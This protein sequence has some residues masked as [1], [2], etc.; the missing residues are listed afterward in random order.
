MSSF[1]PL[2]IEI[3]EELETIYLE[4]ENL[5]ADNIWEWTQKYRK[6]I[7]G[8]D[9]NFDL[10]PF[11]REFYIDNHQRKGALC[12]RQVYKSTAATDLLAYLPTTKSFVS[13]GYI[14]HDPDSLEAFSTER[15]REGTFMA[16][17]ELAKF[18]P[19]GRA[20]VKTIKL[21]NHSRIYFRHSQR[22]Y[23][24]VEGLTL[25]TLVLDEAQKQ[26]V[27]KLRVARH[28]IRTTKGP[29]IMFGI[30]GEEGSS[31]HDLVIRN[32]EIY[33]WVY[34]DTSDYTDGKTGKVWPNQGWRHKLDFDED[35]NVTN[36]KKDL[37]QILKGKMVKIHEPTSGVA[38]YKMYHFPQEIF[39]TI[40]LTISDCAKYKMEIDDSIEY[41]QIH[42]SDDIY[43]AHCRG[44][45]YPARGRPLTLEMIRKCYDKSKG[46]LSPAQILEIKKE[47]GNSVYVTA[48]IDWGSNKSGKSYTVLTILLCYRKTEYT[49]DRFAIVYMKKFETE[50]TDMEEAITLIPIIKQ[51]HVDMTTADLGYGKSGVKI[52]QDGLPDLPGLGRDRCK[53]VFTMGNLL[54]ETHTYTSEMEVEGL[55]NPYL[56]VHKTERVD[57]LIRLIKSRVPD[58]DDPTNENKSIP[59]LTIP[60]ENPIDVDSLEQGLVKI[61]RADLE[62]NS[63]LG[64]KME[65]DKRQKAEKLYEHYW[66]EV[67]AL[68][69]AI[70]AYENYN[71]S[72]STISPVK[73]R[74]R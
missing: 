62:D 31:W 3:K 12:G 41:Q 60:Y 2:Y 27:T 42:E 24:K 15:V 5:K 18:L 66:D 59:K 16:N 4:Q 64:V 26:D 56:S 47:F 1:S 61:K 70:I 7:G 58:R 63:T 43:Q 20:N 51:Y 40:P 74:K 21:T 69:H 34:D 39:A 72:A 50:S 37:N 57:S 23:S 32:A 67:S 55:K 68:I 28:T 14:V 45:F 49:P 46:F 71:P 6:K 25:W 52:L 8:K 30:G 19:H 13:T 44:W 11:W 36:D 65:G 35:G 33:D 54:E 9:R 22:N 73:S 29:L 10:I 53:G 48:G 17:P 38:T